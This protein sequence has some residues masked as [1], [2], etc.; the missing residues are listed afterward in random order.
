M[1]GT[2]LG[3]DEIHPLQAGCPPVQAGHGEPRL[4]FRENS[5]EVSTGVDAARW[6]RASPPNPARFLCHPGEHSSRGGHALWPW[7][8]NACIDVHT[9]YCESD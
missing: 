7:Q 4:G 3:V 6:E 1:D 2:L 9:D 8:T 5:I